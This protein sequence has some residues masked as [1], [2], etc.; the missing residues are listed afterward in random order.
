[1][2][3]CSDVERRRE[4]Y[5]LNAG[6]IVGMRVACTPKMALK[7]YVGRLQQ[8]PKRSVKDMDFDF[9]KRKNCVETF[10][11]LYFA[12]RRINSLVDGLNS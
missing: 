10:W 4:L 8:S 6:K 5:Q 12:S 1:M 2:L 3:E 7:M 11:F 9:R